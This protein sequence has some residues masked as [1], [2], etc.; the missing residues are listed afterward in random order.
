[1][2]LL[3]K[4]RH[5]SSECVVYNGCCEWEL[6]GAGGLCVRVNSTLEHL[7]PLG[8]VKSGMCVCVFVFVGETFDLVRSVF[9]AWPLSCLFTP[10]K[11]LGLIKPTLAQRKHIKEMM[12]APTGEGSDGY[13]WW[14]ALAGRE[15]WGLHT[16]RRALPLRA[17]DRQAQGRLWHT[18]ASTHVPLHV[19][20]RTHVRTNA[21]AFTIAH[22]QK[23]THIL[24]SCCAG[25]WVAPVAAHALF[26]FTDPPSKLNNNTLRDSLSKR[27]SLLCFTDSLHSYIWNKALCLSV[28]C[29]YESQSPS[30][31]N[32]AYFLS[33][34]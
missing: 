28:S 12:K 14:A 24:S 31:W 10:V 2:P 7:S 19:Y 11:S 27:G 3:Y 22:T 21:H 18:Y 33:V 1:M 16:E 9:A 13:W 20:A 30:I 25:D 6:Y 29:Y 8:C 4:K 26:H 34:W 15:A 17:W 32:H 5:L 23:H